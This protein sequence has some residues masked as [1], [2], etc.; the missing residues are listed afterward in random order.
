MLDRRV[1]DEPYAAFLHDAFE[2]HAE[3]VAI[4][5]FLA[6]CVNASDQP[7]REIRRRFRERRFEIAARVGIQR[8]LFTPE[9][10]LIVDHAPCAVESA[11]VGIDDQLAVA[12][13]AE[14]DSAGCARDKGMHERATV[15]R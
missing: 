8:L 1:V 9:A 3:R 10:P 2:T 15:E 6:R 7:L 12:R 4:A 11:G 14:I 13:I 5:D